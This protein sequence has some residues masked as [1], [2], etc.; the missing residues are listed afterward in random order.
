MKLAAKLEKTKSSTDPR[1]DEARFHLSA[2]SSVFF[3]V[4]FFVG[5]QFPAAGQNKGKR[6]GGTAT[7][8]EENGRQRESGS[9]P[10]ELEDTQT[11]RRRRAAIMNDEPIPSMLRDVTSWCF[12]TGALAWRKCV[13]VH[14]HASR[15]SSNQ[16]GGCLAAATASWPLAEREK[17]PVISHAWLW[18]LYLFDL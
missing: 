5:S 18:L 8:R 10:A 11:E 9:A 12:M 7:S 13:S 1:S 16:L 14:C 15:R 2:R 3:N 4:W 17:R 6:E